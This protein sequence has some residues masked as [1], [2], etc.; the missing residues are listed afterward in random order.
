MHL[1]LLA[2]PAR[3]ATLE[4]CATCPWTDLDAAIEAAAD[5]DR[6][7]IAAGAWAVATTLSVDVELVGAGADATT[8][9]AGGE[10]TVLRVDDATV[11]LSDLAV[12]GEARVRGIT[13][14]G[15]SLTLHGATVRNGA[16]ASGAGLYAGD[17]A[18]VSLLDCAFVDNDAA[19]GS[20][21][22]LVVQDGALSVDGCTFQGGRAGSGAGIW[23]SDS[24]LAIQGST[25][26]DH[27]AAPASGSG[28][29]GALRLGTGRLELVDTRFAD[30]EVQGSGAGGSISVT[31]AEVEASGVTVER[32][33]APTGGGLYL[34]GVDATLVD[35]RIADCTADDTAGDSGTARGG[36]IAAFGGS[37]SLSESVLTGNQVAAGATFSAGG[38]IYANATPLTLL[39]VAVLD[40]RVEGLDAVYGGGV[41]LTDADLQAEGLLVRGS[42]VE[43][44]ADGSFG[45]G[46]FVR[47]AGAQVALSDCTVSDNQAETVGGALYASQASEGALELLALSD[48]H[49]EGNASANGGALG[50]R[51]EGPVTIQASRFEGNASDGLGGAI[52]WNPGEDT[53]PGATLSL[54]DTVLR[55]NRAASGGVGGGVSAGWG[56]ALELL[57][58]ELVG[59]ESPD[60]GGLYVYGVGQ[61]SVAHSVFCGNAATEDDG[62]GASLTGTGWAGA[63]EW[64][65]NVLAENRATDNGGGVQYYEWLGSVLV[66]NNSFLGNGTVDNGGGFYG[67]GASDL[68]LVNNLFAW[69]DGGGGVYLG[70]DV[71]SDA[72]TYNA[73]FENEDRDLGG[74]TTTWGTGNLSGEDPLLW[75]YAPGVDCDA[76]VATHDPAGPLADAGD[77]GILDDDGSR[78]DIG[79]YGGAGADPA[80]LLDGDGDGWPGAVDCDDDDPDVHPGAEEIPYNGVDDDCDDGDACDVDGDGYAAEACGGRDCD[81]EEPLISP[82]V[83]DEPGD[84]IDADCDGS[85]GGEG[86]GGSGDGGASDGGSG[87]GGSTDGGA[88]DGGSTDGGS[89]DGGAGDGG[90]A[91]GGGLIDGEDDTGGEGGDKGDGCG[92]ASGGSRGGLLLPGLLILGVLGRRRR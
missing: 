30:N 73:W 3:A 31:D 48:C 38:G 41:Y 9:V 11:S 7:E 53:A 87:D 91:D 37:L 69:T 63:D 68:Q 76:L 17:G 56:D 64:H 72:I 42:V 12:D 90:S 60:G 15:G 57:S 85:D 81:D 4:V 28:F 65:H 61:V 5:G 25:F 43:G 52:Y 88:G 75:A 6:I 62:G 82:A 40:S 36:G 46:L 1:L 58:V 45:G 10:T 34:S 26:T 59:N 71:G 66:V 8:L 22:H 13:Q 21:G 92:C 49:F 19:T 27:V 80:E 77:P 2:L 54:S 24:D 18:T 20:G 51:T 74:A 79:A 23:A 78:S 47:G 70:E 89:T 55:D 84:G 83:E 16:G 32:S 86:D 35:L 67:Y 44:S 14:T 39:D 33:R 29:G 50:L